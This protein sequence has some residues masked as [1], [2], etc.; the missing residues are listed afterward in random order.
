V[1]AFVSGLGSSLL[2]PQATP[3]GGMGL[4][5]GGAPAAGSGSFADALAGLASNAVG[6]LRG[7]ES[8]SLEALRGGGDTRAVVDAVM[9]AEQSLQT[10][11]AIRDKIAAAYL[12]VSRM[13]I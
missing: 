6:T 12:D 8:A 2:S 9:S 5:A 10:A 7:A 13:A 3:L 11:V 1:A 4:A